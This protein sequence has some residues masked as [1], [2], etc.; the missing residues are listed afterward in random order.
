MSEEFYT[1]AQAADRLKLHVKTILRH[2]RDGR[3]P[4]TRIGKSYRLLRQDIVAFAGGERAVDGEPQPIHVTSIVEISALSDK[5][6]D[7]LATMLHASLMGRSNRFERIQCHTAY[8]PS[9]ALL[10]IVLIATPADMA[11]LLTSIQTMADA[12]G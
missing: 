1:V 9:Q 8:D 3:L 2:I 7:R 5:Q 11:A 6:A 10:K 12:L 4:A